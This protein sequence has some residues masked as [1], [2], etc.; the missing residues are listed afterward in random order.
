M[1]TFVVDIDAS[2]LG[3]GVVIMQHKHLVAYF[4][5]VI[6]VGKQG[7]SMYEKEFKA[8]IL[9]VNKWCPYPIGQHFIVRTDNRSL[10]YMLH[11]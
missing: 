7:L 9:V 5:K 4:N 1:Q 3:I 6:I 8:V 11:K 2:S 10:K